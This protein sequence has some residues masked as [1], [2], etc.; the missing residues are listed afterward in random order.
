[1]FHDSLTSLAKRDGVTVAARL[2]VMRVLGFLAVPGSVRHEM[3]IWVVQRNAVVTV[4]L[5]K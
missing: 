2:S 1:M 4:L 5:A 3:R